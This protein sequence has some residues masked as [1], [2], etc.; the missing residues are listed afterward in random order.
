M[1]DTPHGFCG[2]ACMDPSKYSQYKVFEKNLTLAIDDTPCAE[3]FVPDATHYTD[4]QETVTHGV[5]GLLSITLDLYSPTNMVD[6]SC[7]DTPFLG[8]LTCVGIP[9]KGVGPLTIRGTGPYCCPKGATVE[10]PCSGSV[11]V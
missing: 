1:G 4:Y 5:P 9:G 3:Q 11:L 6:H 2:E 8:N 7:C 10:K